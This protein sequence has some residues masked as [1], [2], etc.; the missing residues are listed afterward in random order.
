MGDLFQDTQISW[1]VLTSLRSCR[2]NIILR[3]GYL[4][5]AFA[6]NDAV[7]PEGRGSVVVDAFIDRVELEEKMTETEGKVWRAGFTFAEVYLISF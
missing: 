4:G 5:D 6:Y 7:M 3:R 2:S 1:T